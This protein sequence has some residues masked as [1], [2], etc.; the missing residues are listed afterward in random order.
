MG[1]CYNAKLCLFEP[2]HSENWVIFFAPLNLSKHFIIQ[3]V[4]MH[5]VLVK[6]C[7]KFIHSGKQY[8]ISFLFNPNII[9]VYI[10]H[11]TDNCTYFEKICIK[12][13]IHQPEI[14]W[15]GQIGGEKLQ[16]MTGFEHSKFDSNLFQLYMSG[17]TMISIF[18]RMVTMDCQ[19]KN[20]KLEWEL[21]SLQLINV[22]YS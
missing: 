18:L 6:T 13:S 17:Y 4:I 5:T 7:T 2:S 3:A 16:R 20:A 12:V 1:F 9:P 22:L 14:N 15:N 10:S 8:I 11:I 21:F 19:M